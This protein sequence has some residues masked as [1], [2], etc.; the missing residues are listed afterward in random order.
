MYYELTQSERLLNIIE[1]VNNEF[2][3]FKQ[4]EIRKPALEIFQD[5]P[6]IDGYMTFS[7]YFAN[8]ETY[9]DLY[10]SVMGKIVDLFFNDGSQKV[11]EDILS[12]LWN[13][14][15]HVEDA[16]IDGNAAIDDFINDLY[17]YCK[18]NG[19]EEGEN[20]WLY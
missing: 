18:V 16:S 9:E 13:G 3:T 14:Y 8:M 11:R 19:L 5:A 17:F 10:D 4:E 2:V 12:V 1:E 15:L 7:D 20:I 6:K